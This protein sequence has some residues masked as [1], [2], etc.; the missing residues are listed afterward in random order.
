MAKTSNND[1]IKPFVMEHLTA[2]SE[3]LGQ[4]NAKLIAQSR[5]C[6]PTF[7]IQ[8]IDIRL[9]DSV[10]VHQRRFSKKLKYQIIKFKASIRDN[11][12]WQQL[13]SH[14]LSIDQENI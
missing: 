11:E 10:S 13:S 4:C 6:P 14:R 9:K 12:L 3:E 5:R 1:L 2:I 7:S 8:M